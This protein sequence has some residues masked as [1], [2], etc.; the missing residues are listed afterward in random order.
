MRIVDGPISDEAEVNFMTAYRNDLTNPFEKFAEV[1]LRVGVIDNPTLARENDGLIDPL[2]PKKIINTVK[3]KFS[4]RWLNVEGGLIR[5]GLYDEST[6]ENNY[7]DLSDREP[8]SF[9]HP[10]MWANDSNWMG[11]NYLPP[12]GSIV[13]VGFRTNNFPVMLGFVQSHYQVCEPLRLGEMMLKGYGKNTSHWKQTNEIEHKAW[14]NQGDKDASGAHSNQDVY[15]KLRLKASSGLDDDK[16]D[17]ENYLINREN[18]SGLIDLVAYNVINGVTENVST[19]EIK[20]G[21]ISLMTYDYEDQVKE[22]DL[23]SYGKITLQLYED[24]TVKDSI[25]KKSKITMKA[26]DIVMEGKKITFKADEII[27]NNNGS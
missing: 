1:R 4:I 16:E 25:V 14:I 24:L 15:L 18:K 27:E 13:V 17:D 26:D 3:G 11:F 8:L 10:V 23:Q 20:P 6:D 19:I 7:D 21:E 2:N 9:T 5:G 12:V 22:E